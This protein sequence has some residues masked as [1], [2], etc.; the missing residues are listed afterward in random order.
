V[1]LQTH[2]PTNREDQRLKWLAKRETFPV[3]ILCDFYFLGIAEYERD[4][5]FPLHSPFLKRV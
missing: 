2:S 3:K 4:K 1:D 5:N